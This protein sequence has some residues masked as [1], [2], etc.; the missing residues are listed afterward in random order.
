MWNSQSTR[1]EVPCTKNIQNGEKMIK[2]DNYRLLD[3]IAETNYARLYKA[4]KCIP[5]E[6]TAWSSWDAPEGIPCETTE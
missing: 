1:Y 3:I 4:V 6:T 2:I 5:C